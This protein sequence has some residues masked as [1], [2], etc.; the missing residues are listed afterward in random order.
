MTKRLDPA[1]S[2]TRP[3]ADRLAAQPVPRALIADQATDETAVRQKVTHRQRAT[4][5]LDAA[6]RAVEIAIED[7]EAAAL[8]H[9]AAA[10]PP[11]AAA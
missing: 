4:H 11:D 1:P 3:A 6:R 7:S 2:I 9:L 10:T 8:V 5:L